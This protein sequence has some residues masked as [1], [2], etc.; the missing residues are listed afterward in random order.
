MLSTTTA[1]AT[2]ATV[3]TAFGDDRNTLA[4]LRRS[5]KCRTRRLVSRSC[6]DCSTRRLVK[7]NHWDCSTRLLVCRN[8]RDYSTSLLVSRSYGDYSTS[9]L[10][11]RTVASVSAVST[12]S[13]S[14]RRSSSAR[15]R[16][17]DSSC[18]TFRG[19]QDYMSKHFTLGLSRVFVTLALKDQELHVATAEASAKHVRL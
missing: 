14:V 8:C 16:F 12:A 13:V 1:T 4:S 5:Y 9:L 19:Q 17:F 2:S 10:V 15:Q 7:T 18:S 3:W 11:S 6:E